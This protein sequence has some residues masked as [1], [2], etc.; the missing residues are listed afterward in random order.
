MFWVEV[1]KINNHYKSDH[2][3]K[4]MRKLNLGERPDGHCDAIYLFFLINA[5]FYFYQI[6][7]PL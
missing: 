1:D 3:L 4:V 2:D 5:Y 7:K 6:Y